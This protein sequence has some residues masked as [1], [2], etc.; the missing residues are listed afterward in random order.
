MPEE[1]AGMTGPVGDGTEA[2]AATGLETDSTG[3]EEGAVAGVLAATEVEEEAPA[4][5]AVWEPVWDPAWGAKVPTLQVSE[6]GVKATLSPFM[7]ETRRPL[8][9]VEPEP[10]RELSGWTAR[11]RGPAGLSMWTIKVFGAFS[12]V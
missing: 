2:C 5:E 11:A 1:V 6:R 12:T 10:R 4:L 8:M 9:V 7:P 3:G